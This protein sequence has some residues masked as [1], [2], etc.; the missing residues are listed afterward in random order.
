M[1]ENYS[2]EYEQKSR[3]LD[4]QHERQVDSS[5]EQV[6]SGMAEGFVPSALLGGS[7]GH[8]ANTTVRTITMQNAQKTHGNRA[9]QR[10]LQRNA[11][12]Q[13]EV[14]P[15]SEPLRVQRFLDELMAPIPEPFVL[16]GMGGS[17]KLP[18]FDGLPDLQE[19]GI[20]MPFLPNLGGSGDFEMP[21]G[22]DDPLKVDP[23]L[24]LE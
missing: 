11:L 4:S 1:A 20:G 22:V 19:L 7:W 15:E 5:S 13:S 9:V 21:C 12:T 3:Q 16:P 14:L 17:G 10:L 6:P 24:L 8:R 18:S 23:E 2:T